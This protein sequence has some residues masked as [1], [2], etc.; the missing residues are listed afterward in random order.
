MLLETGLTELGA[1]ALERQLIKIFGRENI[2]D[3]GILLNSAEGGPNG[4]I[5]GE[6][7]SKMAK[8]RW[9]DPNFVGNSKE[10]QMQNSQRLMELWQDKNS[11]YNSIEYRAKRST[12]TKELWAKEGSPLGTKECNVKRAS[13]QTINWNNPEST[14]HTEEYKRK[15]AASCQHRYYFEKDGVAFCI[16]GAKN[17]R[18]FCNENAINGNKILALIKGKIQFYD[19]WNVSLIRKSKKELI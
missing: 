4:F 8:D 15:R 17:V 11:I 14:Y 1:F 5:S 19:G 13:S 10:Y 16:Q 12:A 6:L 18:K 2:N 9:A 3:T 7:L